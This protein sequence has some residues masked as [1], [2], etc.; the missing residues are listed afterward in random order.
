[1]P[2]V[3]DAH[4][5]EP[6][7]RADTFPRPVDVGH[8]RA[9]LGARNDPGIAGLAWQVREDADRRRGQVNRAGR[10][11]SHRRGEFL[12]RR[13]RHAPSAGSGF[14]FGGSR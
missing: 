6:G 8:V 12:P 5:A 2:D 4:V 14:R 1:M 3:M 9:R 13:D 10:Q 11:F 7:L